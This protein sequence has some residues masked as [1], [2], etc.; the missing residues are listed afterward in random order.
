MKINLNQFDLIIFDFDGVIIDSNDIK[1]EA[2]KKS[3][4]NESKENIEN[5]IKY[6]KLNFNISRY[7]KFE[8]FYSKIKKINKKKLKFSMKNTLLKYSKINKELSLKSRVI[9]GLTNFLKKLRKLNI[10]L[11]V[12]S[13]SDTDDIK[14]VLKKKNLSKYFSEVLGSPTSKKKHFKNI[15]NNLNNKIQV[16]SLGDSKNDYLISKSM[17]F[18]FIYI[19]SKSFWFGDNKM[20]KNIKY[21]L[22]NFSRKEVKNIFY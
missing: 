20:K 17:A 9:Y 8:H 1:T 14:F 4:K 10:K 11:I 5:F 15:K 12:I 3:I 21:N 2:F 13:S 6:H 7:K 19:K 16:L 18:D 22:K